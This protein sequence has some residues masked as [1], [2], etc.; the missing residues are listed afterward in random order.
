MK[1]FWK[2]FLIT[3]LILLLLMAAG[4]FYVFMT[5]QPN[6]LKP[7]VSHYFQQKYQR[8]CIIPGD[9]Q[10]SLWPVLHIESGPVSLMEKDGQAIFASLE[11]AKISL[12]WRPL[13]EGRLDVSDVTLI[14]PAVH[15][16][17]Y[18]DGTTNFDD[19]LASDGGAPAPFDI[20]GLTIKR[21]SWSFDDQ[22]TQWKMTQANLHVGRLANAVPTDFS[23]DGDLQLNQDQFALHMEMKSP[24]LFDLT[25]QKI[26]MEKLVLAIKGQSKAANTATLNDIALNATGA[27]AFDGAKKLTQFADWTLHSQLVNGEEKWRAKVAF[28]EAEQQGKNWRAKNISSQ[29]EQETATYR[30][31]TALS[32]PEMQFVDA[33]M[34]GKALTLTAQWRAK[35]DTK[36][37]SAQKKPNTLDG[38]LTLGA[39]DDESVRGD[40]AATYNLHA[41]HV[42]T[43]GLIDG[44][45]MQFQADG[46]VQILNNNQIV[47]KGPLKAQFNYQPAGLALEGAVK[48]EVKM[49][50]A[51]AQYDVSPLTLDLKITPADFSKPIALI[52]SGGVNADLKRKSISG[53]LH[54]KL[55]DAK[56]DA[57]LGVTGFAPPAYSFDVLLSE[58]NTAWFD[59]K[60]SAT[61]TPADLPDFGWLKKLN[62]HGV[63]RIGELVAA[64]KRATNVRI[65]VKSDK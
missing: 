10:L 40:Q 37:N 43:K 21:A 7:R 45:P 22:A 41:A 9:L 17:R 38:L 5:F 1:K 31:N 18:A 32:M 61:N 44:A 6:D 49:N 53:K 55:N 50:L 4:I 8:Q 65:E 20:K 30:L 19:F 29:A 15:L 39:I 58:F 12:Q 28:S 52:G 47:T 14:A 13:I 35:P 57:T 46:D 24:L 59:N 62:A 51:N 27:M 26:Q 56:L 64:D 2:I 34:R 3:L 60:T 48:T 16:K 42:E 23:F 63:L 25:T 11:A 33:R 36:K 54:G